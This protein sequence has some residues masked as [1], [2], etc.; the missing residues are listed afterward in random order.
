MS[1]ACAASERR[2]R[3]STASGVRSGHGVIPLEASSGHGGCGC[4]RP[5]G[6]P[7]TR[8]SP[9]PPGPRSTRSTSATRWARGSRS[10]L[11]TSRPAREDRS[12]RMPWA[13]TRSGERRPGAPGQA[14]VHDRAAQ[15]GRGVSI[16]SQRPWARR[17]RHGRSPRPLPAAR[18]SG[19]RPAATG[20]AGRGTGRL[21]PRHQASWPRPP[22]GFGRPVGSQPQLITDRTRWFPTVRRAPSRR[23]VR[24]RARR[25]RSPSMRWVVA[26]SS[27]RRIP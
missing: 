16:L 4:D 1:W 14:Q 10:R 21:R 3:S 6:Q 7:M 12:G 27:W 20:H 2:R 25:S 11:P 23:P 26:R 13:R 9:R 19:T 8:G 24:R 18:S 22:C 5:G 17:T 15:V